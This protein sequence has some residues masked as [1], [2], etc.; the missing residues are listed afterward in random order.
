M[1]CGRGL[2]VNLRAEAMAG[3]PIG[4]LR[5]LAEDY[6]KK[7]KGAPAAF[8]EYVKE[9]FGKGELNLDS[10][11]AFAKKIPQSCRDV[12]INKELNKVSKKKIKEAILAEAKKLRID[13]AKSQSQERSDKRS[14]EE[15]GKH[16]TTVLRVKVTAGDV[17]LQRKSRREAKGVG[18]VYVLLNEQEA[19]KFIKEAEERDQ[20]PGRAA[21][22]IVACNPSE[23]EDKKKDQEKEKKWEEK[24]LR[25]SAAR[26]VAAQTN[27][28]SKPLKIWLLQLGR[29]KA[30]LNEPSLIKVKTDIPDTT[31]VPIFLKKQ[32]AEK[33]VFAA[34][35]KNPRK[36]IQHMIKELNIEECVIGAP[37]G[38]RPVQ[39]YV[40]DRLEENGAIRAWIIV[41]AKGN[42]YIKLC[43]K[44]GVKGLF[45]RTPKNSEEPIV[46][47]P[48]ETLFADALKQ[49]AKMKEGY[50][51]IVT[52]RKGLAMRT[53]VEKLKEVREAISPD[54]DF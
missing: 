46:Q 24:G 15:A 40:N 17:Q 51:G 41:K 8:R 42:D 19:E 43:K 3:A 29:E 50:R 1:I 6:G 54:N 31:T 53:I 52:T 20:Y 36:I 34:A 10:T 22:I 47:F 7:T 35:L 12:I 21:A 13:I 28:Q 49:G 26:H 27:G 23:L 39:D 11:E 2:A 4:K 14:G 25:P 32:Y 48:S 18:D 30:V 9:V 37:E 33:E 44:T 5:E 16:D 45:V 38:V